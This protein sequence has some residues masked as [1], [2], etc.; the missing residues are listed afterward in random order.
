MR[1]CEKKDLSTFKEYSFQVSVKGNSTINGGNGTG[2]SELDFEY[3][4]KN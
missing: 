1:V 4:L 3:V 2:N